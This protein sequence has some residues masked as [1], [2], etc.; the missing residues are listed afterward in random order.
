MCYTIRFSCAKLPVFGRGLRNQVLAMLIFKWFN[1]EVFFPPFLLNLHSPFPICCVFECFT[2]FYVCVP[3]GCLVSRGW[4]R[5]LTPLGLEVDTV[6]CC[7]VGAG[8]ESWFSR[9][10]VRVLNDWALT[11]ISPLPPFWDRASLC[12]CGDLESLVDQAWRLTCLYPWSAGI[13]DIWASYEHF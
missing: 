7:H 3:H 12:S 2:C 13:K 1:P 8:S 5:T 4:K 11:N 6:V 10:T 9:E